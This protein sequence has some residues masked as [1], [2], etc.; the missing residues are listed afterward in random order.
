[1]A[2]D[3]D[4]LKQIQR[5]LENIRKEQESLS[6]KLQELEKAISEIKKSNQHS[7]K[8]VVKY[9]VTID[10]HANTYVVYHLDTGA[11]NTLAITGDKLKLPAKS[12]IE[13]P[14]KI[15]GKPGPGVVLADKELAKFVFPSYIDFH[16]L[17]LV[18]PTN[19]S[20]ELKVGDVIAFALKD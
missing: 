15:K 11:K 16:T 5:E 6:K 10:P 4:F 1:M 12:S 17:I 2:K 14:I 13:I 19:R 18:N 9:Q 3:K 8:G 20:F 7:S